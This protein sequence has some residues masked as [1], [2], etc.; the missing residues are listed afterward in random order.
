MCSP[1]NLNTCYKVY[2][3]KEKQN[4][5]QA[6]IIILGLGPGDPGFI[7]R[8]A[9]DVISS[10]KEIFLRTRDHPTISGFPKDLIIHSFDHIYDEED[11]FQVVYRRISEEIIGRAKNKPGIVYAV[12]G[13][14]FTAE[15]T[16]ALIISLAREEKLEVE[17]IPGVSF[18]ESV[19]AAL[20]IDPLP[21]LTIL[22]ALDFQDTYFPAFPPDRPALI[23]QIHSRETASNLKLIL[24]E[25]YP[26]NHPVRLVHDASSDNEEIEDIPLCELDR[27]PKIHNRT[28]L[29]IPPLVMGSSLES[30]QEVIAHLRAPDGCPWDREQDHQSLRPNLLE[31][32]FE[33]LEAIDA[34]D[35]EKMQ[36]EFG[37]LLLQIILHSQI[38]S[39]YGEFTMSDVIRGIYHKIIQR[40]PHVFEGLSLDQPDEVIRNWESIKAREREQ[41]GEKN[42][43]LLDGVPGSLPSLTQAQTYQ[44][45]AARMGFDWEEI[46]GVLDKIPEE[47]QEIKGADD[48]IERTAE[49]GDLL[50]AL[51]NIA[52]WLDIDAESALRGANRRFK[53]RFSYIEKEARASGRELSKMTFEELDSLW[54]RAKRDRDD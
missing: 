43:G 11:S 17:I 26:D 34:N 53:D 24:M 14:P 3:G 23:A 8:R 9:W 22:D 27:S 35:P 12:P 42:R 21:Q 38:A 10:S 7:T 32:T 29:Y 19:F 45:R 13:D 18:L 47:I 36:E 15:D 16:P 54:E 25:L 44:K 33:V 52:R 28:A 48:Q 41:N 5:N 39:E 49:F 6:D 46:E 1:F 37:D 40:H 20:E 2:M 4:Q 51:V 31:E 50:F 30:F